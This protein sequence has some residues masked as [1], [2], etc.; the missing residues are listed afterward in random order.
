MENT[1]LIYKPLSI[2]KGFEL[3]LTCK[4]NFAQWFLIALEQH[5]KCDHARIEFKIELF[6]FFY[7]HIMVYDFRHWDYENDCFYEYDLE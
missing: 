3:Q 6:K 2:N 7:F 1:I 5:S 4:F